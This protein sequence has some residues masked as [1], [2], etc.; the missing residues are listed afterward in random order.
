[1]NDGGS[2]G[3]AG[4]ATGGTAGASGG[5]AGSGGSSGSGGSIAAGGSAGTGASGSSA[6]SSGSAGTAG[7]GAGGSAGSAGSAGTGGGTAIG[8]CDAIIEDDALGCNGFGAATIT[9]NTTWSAGCQEYTNLV[10]DAV[11]VTADTDPF[12]KPTTIIADTIELKLG[13]TLTATGKGYAKGTGPGKGNTINQYGSGGGHGGKGADR[14]TAVGGVVYGD[15]MLPTTAGSGGGIGTGNTGGAGGGAL[16]LCAR[17]SLIVN[18]SI[19]SDGGGS[20]P[21]GAGA[22]GSLLLISPLISGAGALS[23]KG[24]LAEYPACG[25]VGASGGGGRIALRATTNS[26]TGTINVDGVSNC[27]LTSDNG[28]SFIGALP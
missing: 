10:I 12:G 4:A 7:G 1:M 3:S 24:G 5:S 11:T 2:G 16:R 13:A 14:G 6:G 18:G 27:G 22:G 9:A 28:T 17:Q 26:F 21:G 8:P 20:G 23:A 19:L 15:R 25:G